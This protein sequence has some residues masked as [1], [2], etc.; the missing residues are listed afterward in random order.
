MSNSDDWSD[1]QNVIDPIIEADLLNISKILA[2]PFLPPPS[3]HPARK[4]KKHKKQNLLNT[5]TRCFKLT[6]HIELAEASLETFTRWVQLSR[7]P[8]RG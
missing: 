2:H 6:P 7:L 1:F 4:M 5:A 3:I 8:P